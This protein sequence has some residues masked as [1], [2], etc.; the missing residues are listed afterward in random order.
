MTNTT[1][2]ARRSLRQ[3]AFALVFSLVYSLPAHAMLVDFEF[4]S[5]VSGGTLD[6]GGGPVDLTGSAVTV[7]G[8]TVSDVDANPGNPDIGAYAAVTRFDFGALGVFDADIA[9]STFY[10]Q[11]CVSAS[12]VNCIGVFFNIPDFVSGFGTIIQ[13]VVLDPNLGAFALGSGNG[14]SGVGNAAGA[15]VNSLGQTLSVNILG[16]ENVVY[17]VVPAAVSEPSA[18]LLVGLGLTGLAALR[19]SHAPAV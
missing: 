10:F 17:N 4:R 7:T 11:D 15:I 16:G 13:P 19:R 5:I 18:L 2:I 8:T 12:T 1:H 3:F 14:A 9:G 6:L